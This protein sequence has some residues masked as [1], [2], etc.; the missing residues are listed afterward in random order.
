MISVLSAEVPAGSEWRGE[1]GRRAGSGG[2]GTLL[3]QR[4]PSAINGS[5][6]MWAETDRRCQRTGGVNG[7]AAAR[8]RDYDSLSYGVVNS[9]TSA[10]VFAPGHIQ[11][12]S[13]THS[14]R[15]AERPFSR[16]T[17][18]RLKS[19][20]HQLV[21]YCDATSASLRRHFDVT[22][23]SLR[24][25]LRLFELHNTVGDRITRR[26]FLRG[27]ISKLEINSAKG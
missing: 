13:V 7:P 12:A 14:A 9:F 15:R 1:D 23:A 24:R 16:S 4:F 22:S 5:R 25:H 10:H 27:N 17:K 21:Q 6:G 18:L 11:R 26:F 20:P 3:F 19:A 8:R 2:S